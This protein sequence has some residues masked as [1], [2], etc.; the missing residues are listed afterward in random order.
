VLDV[1]HMFVHP[2]GQYGVVVWL[3]AALLLASEYLFLPASGS[4][5]AHQ[6]SLRMPPG[7]L[8]RRRQVAKVV[9]GIFFQVCQRRHLIGH[10][11]RV[12]VATL[13]GHTTPP[14]LT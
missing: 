3:S 13:E 5:P 11:Q 4:S 14:H 6:P 10:G 9:G 1:L 8:I 2:M 12:P 7:P